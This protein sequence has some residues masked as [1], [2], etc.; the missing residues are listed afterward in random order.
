MILS[1]HPQANLLQSST[2]AQIKDNWGNERLSF[3]KD[4][5]LVA[6]RCPD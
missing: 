4:G 2:W 3:Y 6:V 1:A 5:H